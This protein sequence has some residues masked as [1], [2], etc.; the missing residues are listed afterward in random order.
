MDI[1]KTLIRSENDVEG[2]TQLAASIQATLLSE[3]KTPIHLLA[4]RVRTIFLAADLLDDALLR[5]FN[6]AMTREASLRLAL[7]ELFSRFAAPTENLKLAQT[8]EKVEWLVLVT[9]ACAAQKGYI[10][11]NLDPAS[12]PRT[13]SP[14]GIMLSQIADY[15]RAQTRRTATER[16]RL[17]K[18]LAYNPSLAHVPLTSA[19]SNQTGSTN[20]ENVRSPAPV[21]YFEHNPAIKLTEADLDLPPQ[22]VVT[23]PP[24][25]VDM[26]TA[27]PAQPVAP[28]T[29]N[30][31]VTP[32]TMPPIKISRDSVTPLSEKVTAQA[33]NAWR[34]IGAP[35]V[36]SVANKMRD[37]LA[38][39]ETTTTL[40]RVNVL[41]RPEGNGIVGV[42][43]TVT[44]KGLRSHVAGITDRDGR[45]ACELPVREASGLT[46]DVMVSWPREMGADREKKSITLSGDR[47][48]FDLPFFRSLT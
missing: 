48:D 20:A 42:Q 2:L 15:F 16:D 14:A 9:L 13:N 17:A 31:P 29:P 36:N 46:Y 38:T 44:C 39:E 32:Q 18:K 21:T 43:V 6:Q 25:S 37:L 41:D 40:L 33:S 1:G 19:P 34:E 8:D 47:G 23:T 7:D 30:P 4:S 26:P 5:E 45:F 24:V 3:I 11:E 12:P 10:I 27:P 22:T 28:Q 35:A